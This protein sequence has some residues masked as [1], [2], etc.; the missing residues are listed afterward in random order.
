MDGANRLIF[1]GVYTHSL[2]EKGRVT[3]PGPHRTMLSV[4]RSPNLF[5]LGYMPGNQYLNLYP[6]EKWETI[7]EQWSDES[8]FPS[9]DDYMRAQRL[10]FGRV[11]EVTPDKAGRILIPPTHRDAIGLTREAVICGCRDKI[12]IWEPNAYKSY[13]KKV[14]ELELLRRES[15]LDPGAAP[16]EG[17]R[18]PSW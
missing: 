9:T 1:C 15:S 12:E 16:S 6:L 11:E 18:F 7:L 17:P 2:D 5:H 3:L 14:E 13:M 4:S 8:R 10:F